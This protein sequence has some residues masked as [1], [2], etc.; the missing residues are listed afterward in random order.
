MARSMAEPHLA[1]GRLVIPFDANTGK[2][3]FAYYLLYPESRARAAAII[4]FRDW[5]LNEFSVTVT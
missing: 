1:S 3:G 4:A 2:D 5:I